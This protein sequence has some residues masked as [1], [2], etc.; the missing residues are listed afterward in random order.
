MS[1]Y[2]NG[3]V[4]GLSPVLALLASAIF[5]VLVVLGRRIVLALLRL[6]RLSKSHAII[7]R[8][9]ERSPYGDHEGR[10]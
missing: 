5:V 1:T 10:K 3:G 7:L 8:S 4:N 2:L 9:Y 6:R